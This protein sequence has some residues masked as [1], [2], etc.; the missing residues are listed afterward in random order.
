M[1][2]IDFSYTDKTKHRAKCVD[3]FWFTVENK[4]SE[5]SHPLRKEI[6]NK[7]SNRY[8][9]LP[10]KNHSNYEDLAVSWSYYCDNHCSVSRK[11]DF[12]LKRAT[13]VNPWWS[14]LLRRVHQMETAGVEQ[15]LANYTSHVPVMCMRLW[16]FLLVTNQECVHH[17]GHNGERLDRAPV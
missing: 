2:R 3:D 14:N 12:M 1:D 7:E 16:V 8:K 5:G 15:H 13:R 4:I 10:K 17:V 11:K 9:D 6:K